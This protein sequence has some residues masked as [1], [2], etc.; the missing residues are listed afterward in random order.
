MTNKEIRAIETR[1]VELRKKIEKD[2]NAYIKYSFLVSLL[3]NLGYDLEFSTVYKNG[4]AV[5][6]PEN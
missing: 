3:N 4:V 6:D 2:H 5:L 1:A